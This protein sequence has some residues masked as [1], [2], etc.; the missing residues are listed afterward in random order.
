MIVHCPSCG[1]GI[2][3]DAEL[4]LDDA[5]ARVE[6]AEAERAEEKRI[7]AYT[8]EPADQGEVK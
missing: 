4:A 1:V 5:L 3:A 7:S 8:G 6:R 2:D